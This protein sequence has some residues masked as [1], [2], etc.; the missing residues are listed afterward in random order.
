MFKYSLSLN[1]AAVLQFSL[2]FVK[3]R[4]WNSEQENLLKDF[5]KEK[6]AATFLAEFSSSS[7]YAIL[8][9]LLLSK[10]LFFLFSV[11]FDILSLHGGE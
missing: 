10:Y 1:I 4:I 7:A 6:Y 3:G 8:S 2:F 9:H 11:Q 5:T